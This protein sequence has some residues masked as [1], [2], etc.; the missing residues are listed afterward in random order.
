LR[1][2]RFS[3]KRISTLLSFAGSIIKL[4]VWVFAVVWVLNEFGIEPASKEALAEKG[5]E[6][7][8][9]P[10]VFFIDRIETFRKLFSRRLS[11]EEI[12]R[13]LAPETPELTAGQAKSPPEKSDPKVAPRPSRKL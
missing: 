9:E 1:R 11:E 6:L 10:N 12:V 13:D 4:F 5:V 8:G 7:A 2:A 3:V